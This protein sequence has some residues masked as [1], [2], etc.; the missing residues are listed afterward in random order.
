MIVLGVDPGS[1]RTGYGVIAGTQS[2]YA[3]LG[4]GLIR[5]VASGTFHERIGELC[6]GLDEV[7]A[8]MRPEAVAIETAFVGRN[9]RSAL[10]LGQVRGAVLATVIR[11]GLPVREYAPR[12]IKLSVTGSG[13]ARKEQVAAMLFHLL[14]LEQK[15]KS[16][17]VTDALGIAYCDL[18]RGAS[19]VYRTEGL[20][21]KGR[22]S[23][24]K[25][26]AAFVDDHQ[27]LVTAGGSAVTVV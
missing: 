8:A 19:T 20:P 11:H 27:E 10:I 18:S 9:V 7:I 24:S 14:D 21:K 16:L 22:N 15:P 2:G 23:R 5:P 1:R 4:C 13:S 25:G 26:W 17:D 3:V 12:E 6:T